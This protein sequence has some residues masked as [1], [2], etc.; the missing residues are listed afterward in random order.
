MIVTALIILSTTRADA[1]IDSGTGSVLL[2]MALA[3]V[4]GASFMAKTFWNT[5]VAKL[6]RRSDKS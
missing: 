6:G 4:L 5:F 3:G 1:Y 2:Q